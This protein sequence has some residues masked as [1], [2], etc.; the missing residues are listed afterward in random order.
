MKLKNLLFAAI[1]A[2]A[3]ISCGKDDGP[4]PATN[5]A[6]TIAE[7]TF[8]ASEGISD[9]ATIGTVKAN[10]ED[11]DGLTFS[12]TT[13]DNDLFEITNAG[14]LGL[15]SGKSLDFATAKTHSITVGVTDGTDSANAT[16]T[17]NVTAVDPEN[18]AP[19][20][21]A[22]EFEADE[23]VD[24]ED[25]IGTVSA[26]DTDGNT[27]TFSITADAS[28]LF[29][30][31][32]T[33]EISLAADKTLDFETSEE[34]T[35]TVSVSDGQ[36][37]A[38]SQVTITVANVNEAPII[39]AQEFEVAEDISDQALIGTI[40]ANDPDGDPL[41]FDITTDDS[42]LFEIDPS[43]AEVTL[44]EGNNLDFETSEEHTI[45]VGISDGEHTVEAQMTITVTNVIE[46]LAEDPNSFVTT[47]KTD[48][49]GKTITIESYLG[50]SFDFTIDWGDG[51]EEQISSNDL[52]KISHEY[53]FAGTYTVAINGT[54]PHFGVDPENASNEKLMSIEQWG[55][56]QWKSFYYSFENCSNMVYNATDVPDLSQATDMSSM[57]D[58][59]SSFNGDLSGWQVDNVLDMSEMF[60][61]ASSFNGDISGWETGEVTNMSYMFFEASMFNRDISGWNVEN[62]SD[63]TH[64]FSSAIAF[65]QNLGD[66]NLNSIFGMEGMLD[67]SGLSP[68]NYSGTL[69]GWGTN[70][71][72][73]NG[74]IFGATGLTYCGNGIAGRDALLAKFWVIVGDSECL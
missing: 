63:M 43:T 5:S 48:A 72:T 39:E 74:I 45:T 26:N 40:V 19:T 53:E 32:D 65:D 33:G 67:N 3:V 29:E 68:E 21:D 20:I 10:D 28:E 38:E 49:D 46:S 58:G 44:T 22:Q 11:G 70:A 55:T 16:I 1:L 13:N 31:S 17:I 14:A 51:S 42:G 41:D 62:A 60:D 2:L 50:Y 34:H 27:L 37:S 35:I 56:I 54:F 15:A 59:A 73:P 66:W 7:Q 36:E 47:W 25:L 61:G 24:D 52:D 18:N 4:E 71:N 57:F 69:V 30:I 6:P 64:M 23:N 9:A 12:I 8:T